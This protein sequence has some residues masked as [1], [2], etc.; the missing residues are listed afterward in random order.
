MEIGITGDIKDK[1][2]VSAD[3]F[4]TVF[5]YTKNSENYMDIF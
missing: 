4:E 5:L 1:E 2:T 3:K